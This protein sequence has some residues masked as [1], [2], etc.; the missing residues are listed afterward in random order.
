MSKVILFYKQHPAAD[1]LVGELD[2]ITE[3]VKQ[4]IEF[5]EKKIEAAKKAF[6]EKKKY[7]WLQ[8]EQYIDENNLAPEGKKAKDL[9]LQV[10]K[11]VECI[12]RCSDD[13][14]NPS[15]LGL[16]LGK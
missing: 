12:K 4:D 2:E 6:V 14:R 16:L 15:L 11:D 10:D 3:K 9:C 1:K 13:G 8:L 5:F 7:L